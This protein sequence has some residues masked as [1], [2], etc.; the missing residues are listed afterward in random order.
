MADLKSV[1]RLLLVKLT[2][3]EVADRAQE[4][5][6]AELYRGQV[7]GDFASEAEDWKEQKKLWESK[8]LTA[9]EACLRLGRVVKDREEHR[10][11]E[12]AVKIEGGVYLMIRL[13]TGEIVV[14]RP[15]TTEELQMALP[16]PE[17]LDPITH[18]K[19]EELKP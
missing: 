3:D 6:K 17:P 19:T 15:A 13:D 8:V 5:A 4:L 1:K 2:L 11:V 14:Q 16:M 18:V 7:Q 9:S 12:C 10:E